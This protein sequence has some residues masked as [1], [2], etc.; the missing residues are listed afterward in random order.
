M[1]VIAGGLIV[2]KA[3][4]LDVFALLLI[5]VWSSCRAYYFAFY[6]I[7]RYVDPNFRFSG[8]FDFAKYMLFGGRVASGRREGE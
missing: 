1:S 2:I 6:V 5:C 3:P 4:R 8:L 7:G